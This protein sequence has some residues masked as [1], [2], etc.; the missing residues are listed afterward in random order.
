VQNARKESNRNWRYAAVIAEEQNE[1]VAMLNEPQ[2]GEVD[3]VGRFLQLTDM[4]FDIQYKVD[5]AIAAPPPQTF[6]CPP[7]YLRPHAT[8]WNECRLRCPSLLPLSVCAH[9]LAC[10]S[11]QALTLATPRNSYGPGNAGIWGYDLSFSL[12]LLILI[13][14]YYYYFCVI[15]YL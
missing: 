12:F 8:G 14:I 5:H 7:S 15:C 4:H 11:F 6:V 10:P 9:S 3:G 2:A 13:L 1:P